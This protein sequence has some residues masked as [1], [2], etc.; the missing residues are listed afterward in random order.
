MR[1]AGIKPQ[2]NRPG[3]RTRRKLILQKYGKQAKVFQEAR[4]RK[5]AEA[6]AKGLA[7]RDTRKDLNASSH[8]P[9]S[10]PRVGGGGGVKGGGENEEDGKMHPSWIAKK[11]QA[12]AI[13]AALSAGANRK[14]TFD[15]D[16]P[17]PKP[18]T[19]LAPAAPP[20]RGGGGGKGGNGGVMRRGEAGDVVK[21]GARAETRDAKNLHPSWAA[22]QQAKETEKSR[23]DAAKNAKPTRIKFDD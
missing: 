21:H 11:K 17:C 16:L 19:A 2:K 20:T 10:A 22:K 3:Q 8:R 12:A 14:T 9:V 5:A 4:E 15:D 18:P 23:I 13:A 7:P 6:A 1:L